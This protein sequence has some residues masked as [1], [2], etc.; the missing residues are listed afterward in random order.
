[1]QTIKAVFATQDE[2]AHAIERLKAPGGL[3]ENDLTVVARADEA[4]T[5]RYEQ[6]AVTRAEGQGSAWSGTLLGAAI[7]GAAGVFLT[8]FAILPALPVLVAGGAAIG[9]LTS[10]G[11]NRSVIDEHVNQAKDVLK[12]GGAIV[13][14]HSD[15]PAS[16]SRAR[17][18]LWSEHAKSVSAPVDD[19][20]PTTT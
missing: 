9:A 2:A 12:E 1:M 17:E 16:L 15:D 20:R 6:G 18:L 10:K 13:F 4:K 19:V 5:V 3:T 14:V 8:S 11:I 7:G